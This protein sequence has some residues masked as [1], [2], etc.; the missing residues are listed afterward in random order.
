MYVTVAL[1]LLSGHF[2]YFETTLRGILLRTLWAFQFRWRCGGVVNW[3]EIT[4]FNDHIVFLVHFDLPH[5]FEILHCLLL[6]KELYEGKIKHRHHIGTK[7]R[8]TIVRL[9]NV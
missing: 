7:T 4:A 2:T 1:T 5:E 8:W 6:S 3:F 9:F